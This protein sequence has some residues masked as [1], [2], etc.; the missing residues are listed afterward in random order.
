M[1]RLCSRSC[2]LKYLGSVLLIWLAVFSVFSTAHAANEGALWGLWETHLA[3]VDDPDTVLEACKKFISENRRDP[4][5]VIAKGIASWHML[6]QGEVEN[7]VTMLRP[8]LE[9][10]ATPLEEGAALIA[11]GWISRLD[12]ELV[13]NALQG[14]YRKEVRYPSAFKDLSGHVGV[15]GLDAWRETDRWGRQWDYRQAGIEGIPGLYGQSYTLQSPELKEQSDFAEA[16]KV[17]Y[18]ANILITPE[19]IISSN[20]STPVV[21][22]SSKEGGANVGVVVGK[23][24]DGVF[25]AYVGRSLVVVCDASHWK[26]FKRP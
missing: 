1:P 12:R 20:S 9:D 24:L 19:R 10:A 13:I 25:M 16:L 5:V 26:V 18:G 21:Q 15:Q 14:Y 2:R 23:S 7:A 4:L 3:S 8:Y 6:Q 22:V 11:R 17:A